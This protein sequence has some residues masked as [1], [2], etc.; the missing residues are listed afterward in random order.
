MEK[1]DR[2]LRFLKVP[3]SQLVINGDLPFEL[4]KWLSINDLQIKRGKLLKNRKLGV[5]K[6]KYFLKR[7]FS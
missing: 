5:Q 7:I 4:S 3:D 6:Y 2:I 1:S